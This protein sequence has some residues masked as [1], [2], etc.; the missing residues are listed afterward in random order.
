[1]GA[2][3]AGWYSYDVLDNGRQ[4]SANEIVPGLQQIDVG[5][6]MPALP[7]V[8]DGFTVLE[9][10]PGHHLVAGWLLPDRTPI[11]TWAFV[12]EPAADGGTRLIVRVRTGPRDDF[13]GMPAWIGRLAI[14]PIHFIMQRKQLLGIARRAERF[15]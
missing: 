12:L 2:G 6:V 5:D 8:T 7:G 4:P 13:L 15:A 3:R 14:R 10:E 11:V 9:V 1:M